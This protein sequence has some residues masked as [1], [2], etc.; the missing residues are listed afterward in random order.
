MATNTTPIVRCPVPT[1]GHPIDHHDL[2]CQDGA[3]RTEGCGCRVTP[4][5]I[6]VALLFG[7][8]TPTPATRISRQPDGSWA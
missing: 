6:A 2:C 5:T 7:D 4:N 3:C 8:L 1:C